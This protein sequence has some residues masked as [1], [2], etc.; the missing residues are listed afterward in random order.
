VIS[1]PPIIVPFNGMDRMDLTLNFIPQ[2]IRVARMETSRPNEMLWDGHNAVFTKQNNKT[3]ISGI[4]TFPTAGTTSQS[5]C[6]PPKY[7]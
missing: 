3:K 6:K 1:L 4:N 7:F 5:T 2:L